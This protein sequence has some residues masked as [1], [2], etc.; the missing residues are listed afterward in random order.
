MC[1]LWTERF[2]PLDRI[3]G[4][5][6]ESTALR[7]HQVV[8]HLAKGETARIAASSADQAASIKR[9]IE[10]ARQEQTVTQRHATDEQ[11]LERKQRSHGEWVAHLQ[12]LVELARPRGGMLTLDRL[13]SLVENTNAAPLHRASAA[14]A[15]SSSVNRDDRK[16]IESIA[17]ATVSPK[18]RI[19]FEVV[20]AQRDQQALCDALAEVEHADERARHLQPG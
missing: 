6:L 20:A 4:I 1:R 3:E 11:R 10:S 15:L 8:L 7:P 14:V 17:K 19:A 13:W 2:I 16:R 18:L 5:A 12:A 9:R